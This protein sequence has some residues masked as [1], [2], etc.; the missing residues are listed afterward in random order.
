[1][2]LGAQN[3][4]KAFPEE[5]MKFSSWDTIQDGFFADKMTPLDIPTTPENFG[6]VHGDFHNGNWMV[7]ARIEDHIGLYSISALDFDLAQRSWFVVDIGTVLFQLNQDLY[8]Y[9]RPNSS[10][11]AYETYFYQFK[12]WLVDSYAKAYGSEIDELDIIKGCE[13]RQQFYSVYYRDFLLPN[14]PEGSD[15]YK[16]IMSWLAFYE[17]GNMPTC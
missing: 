15:G 7:D 16:Y 2:R 3:Y 8:N 17:S 11:E 14:Y 9:V 1:M 13:W 10:Q 12:G 4:A 6:V 5:F